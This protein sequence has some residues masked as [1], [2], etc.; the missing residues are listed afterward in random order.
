MPLTCCRILV[1]DSLNALDGLIGAFFPSVGL[2]Y[3]ELVVLM[4]SKDCP[5]LGVLECRFYLEWIQML[6]LLVGCELV[7]RCYFY[8]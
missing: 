1:I 6:V 8:C 5:K 3:E 7:H 2:Q 4:V